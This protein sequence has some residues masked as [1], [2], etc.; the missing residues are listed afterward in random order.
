MFAFITSLLVN[1]PEQFSIIY[2]VSMEKSHFTADFAVTF[3]SKAQQAL[4]PNMDKNRQ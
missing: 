2:V 3:T 4:L 1:I